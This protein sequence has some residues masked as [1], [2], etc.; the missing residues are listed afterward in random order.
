[1]IPKI[2]YGFVLGFKFCV[3]WWYAQEH[4]EKGRKDTS[5]KINPTMIAF[6]ILEPNQLT[7][8]VQDEAS[9]E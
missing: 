6:S 1:M 2:I 4:E 3:R 5:R 8:P 7:A 9:E